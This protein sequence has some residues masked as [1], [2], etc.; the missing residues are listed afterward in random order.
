MFCPNTEISPSVAS[1]RPAITDS[2][3]V[4][5]HPLGP[6]NKVISPKRTSKSTPRSTSARLSPC[7]NSFFTCLQ[8]TALPGISEI[9]CVISISLPLAAEHDRWFEHQNAANAHQARYDDDEKHSGPG[10]R[11]DLPKQTKSPQI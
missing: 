4:L 3:V 7:P 10:A 8:A 2:R 1:S 11:R 9:A 5:P 6:T